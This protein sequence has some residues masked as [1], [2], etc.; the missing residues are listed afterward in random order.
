MHSFLQATQS[1]TNVKVKVKVKVKVN[2]CAH[3]GIASQQTSAQL[4]IR[5]RM[6]KQQSCNNN[7]H[8]RHG[9][10]TILVSAISIVIISVMLVV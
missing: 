6:G 7:D 1:V 5:T 4:R 3:G 2:V 9:A 10:S 8:H